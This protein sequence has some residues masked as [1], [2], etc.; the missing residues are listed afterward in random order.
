[1]GSNRKRHVLESFPHKEGRSA[2]RPEV[3]KYPFGACE[4]HPK[5]LPLG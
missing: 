2:S 5:D 4:D 3:S 1:M